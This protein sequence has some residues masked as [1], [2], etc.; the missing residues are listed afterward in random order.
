MMKELMTT[1]FISHS[2]YNSGLPTFLTEEW[3]ITVDLSLKVFEAMYDSRILFFGIL[4]IPII[5]LKVQPIL[6]LSKRIRKSWN[7]WIKM[8][9][10]EHILPT[11]QYLR[12]WQ[13][14]TVGNLTVKELSQKTFSIEE[15]VLGFSSLANLT[16]VSALKNYWK[17]RSYFIHVCTYTHAYTRN[18]T[19]TIQI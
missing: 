4:V 6:C 3:Q 11:P 7:S 14:I 13:W 9:V 2:L 15:K 18:C 19:I 12:I 8:K 17:I 5:N 16:I 10:T 1:Q